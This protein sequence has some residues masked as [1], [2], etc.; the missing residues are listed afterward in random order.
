VD[1]L[2][3]A[4]CNNNSPFS[5]TSTIGGSSHEVGTATIARVLSPKLGAVSEM[6]GRWWEVLTLLYLGAKNQIKGLQS[7]SLT[8]TSIP[9]QIM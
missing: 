6:P 3:I 4:L 5:G 2:K 8:Y 1:P 7:P 9:K